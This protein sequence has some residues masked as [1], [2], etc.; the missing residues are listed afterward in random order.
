MN[1]ERSF[2]S[3]ILGGF[4][5]D[6]AF[7]AMTITS[8]VK[9]GSNV[10]T[11]NMMTKVWRPALAMGL[12]LMLVVSVLGCASLEKMM[13]DNPK[14]AIGTAAGAAGGIL[15]GGMIFKST[16]GAIVGGLL[17]GLT[18]GVIGKAM[19]TQKQEYAETAKA[20]N[21]TP[22]QGT[23]VHMEKV[24]ALPAT[25]KAGD[26]IHLISH[27][28]LLTPDPSQEL[29][30]VEW[31]KITKAGQAVGD[32]GLRVQRKGGTWATTIPLTLSNNAEPGVYKVDME[33]QANGSQSSK[34]TTFT[35]K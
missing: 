7:G 1:H 24:E 25:I 20:Y 10:M 21:Y 9:W 14:T 6:I 28:S 33:V 15:L 16:T 34:T 32:P 3:G 30:V 18:G 19:E 29:S 12:C 26:T 22:T 4:V 13:K 8:I 23:I 2:L 17:G 11:R 31:R 27:Y 5:G 35:V